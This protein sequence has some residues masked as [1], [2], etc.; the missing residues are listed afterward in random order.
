M[1]NNSYIYICD[2]TTNDELCKIFLEPKNGE[3]VIAKDVI[4]LEDHLIA[5]LTFSNTLELFDFQD[6][7][8]NPGL[9][10]H[11]NYDS[12]S[13]E[14]SPTSK[15]VFLQKKNRIIAYNIESGKEEYAIR[16]KH[17]Y[18]A[19]FEVCAETNVLIVKDTRRVR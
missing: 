16:L 15:F 17:R 4:W 18:K 6:G 8:P 14:Y 3:L 13:I 10:F 11:V 1:F 19:G 7:T 12:L 2:Q 9:T 5:V